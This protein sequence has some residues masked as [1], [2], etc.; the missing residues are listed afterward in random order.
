M[1]QKSQFTPFKIVTFFYFFQD[2]NKDANDVEIVE[3]SNEQTET[4]TEKSIVNNDTIQSLESNVQFV[5]VTDETDS[6]FNA[7]DNDEFEIV[8][9]DEEDPFAETNNI[10]VKKAREIK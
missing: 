5:E 10:E 6:G 4:T 1:R 9:D 2:S 8:L 3:I 7:E